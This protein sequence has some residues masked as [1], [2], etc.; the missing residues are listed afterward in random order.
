MWEG[1]IT[2]IFGVQIKIKQ[3][4]KPDGMRMTS[5]DKKTDQR[6]GQDNCKLHVESNP[7]VYDDIALQMPQLPMPN[8]QLIPPAGQFLIGQPVQ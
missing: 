7:P 3:Q 8:V 4:R 6:I 5:I 2:K 1:G